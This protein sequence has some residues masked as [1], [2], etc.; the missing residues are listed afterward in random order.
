MNCS[1]GTCSLRGFQ[2]LIGSV[3]PDALEI[4]ARGAEYSLA[5]SVFS[6]FQAEPAHKLT[7]WQMGQLV[8]NWRMR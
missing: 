1:A 7:H 8:Q 5:E 2:I 3:D 6:P 4:S